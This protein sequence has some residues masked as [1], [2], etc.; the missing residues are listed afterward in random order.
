[1]ALFLTLARSNEVL[2]ARWDE[3]DLDGKLWTVPPEHTKRERQHRPPLS[4]PAIKL[5][6]S[7]YMWPLLESAHV[8]SLGLFVGTAATARV[9]YDA[10]CVADVR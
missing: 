4:E 5:L 6:E 7:L 1:M 9:Q 10:R 8:L 2:G 3:I